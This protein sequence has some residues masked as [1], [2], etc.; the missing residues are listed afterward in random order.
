M[1]D[2]TNPPGFAAVDATA[3]TSNEGPWGD[4]KD[5]I[6]A[7]VRAMKESAGRAAAA[8]AGLLTE[9]QDGRYWAA[10]Q[11][12][13]FEEYLKNECGIALRTAQAL[14]RIV[15]VFGDLGVP[16]E[17]LRGFEWSK[18]EPHRAGR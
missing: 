6:R 12:K 14:I 3:G 15:R 11:H 16:A 4:R 1:S 2:T 9:V 8:L 10:W 7:E 13:S 18:V 5:F 17:T